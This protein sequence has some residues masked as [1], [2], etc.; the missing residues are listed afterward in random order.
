L[1]ILSKHNLAA[2]TSQA[3]SGL[4]Y[5]IGIAKLALP[6]WQCQAGIPELALL[7]PL[8]STTNFA[9]LLLLSLH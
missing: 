7:C 2:I 8:Y 4:H 5:Q 6:T 9:K 1:S 3:L